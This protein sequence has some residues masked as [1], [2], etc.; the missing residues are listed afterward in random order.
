MYKHLNV[1]IILKTAV[2]N[3]YIFTNHQQNLRTQPNDSPPNFCRENHHYI[4]TFEDW[5]CPIYMRHSNKKG[6][7]PLLY[8]SRWFGKLS[9]PMILL[10]GDIVMSIFLSVKPAWD[11]PLYYFRMFY[12][13]TTFKNFKENQQWDWGM[14]VCYSRYSGPPSD[15]WFNNSCNNCIY[16]FIFFGLSIRH[17]ESMCTRIT[18]WL[19]I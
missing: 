6:V 11:G 2:H 10:T 3:K 19:D 7:V 17:F 18:K 15:P 12:Y 8:Q 9:N 13:I 16:I 5:S 1:N 4:H 14:D